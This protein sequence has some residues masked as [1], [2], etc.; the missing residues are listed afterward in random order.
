MDELQ[1]LATDAAQNRTTG[2]FVACG[3]GR[4]RT[5]E[6]IERSQTVRKEGR[7]RGNEPLQFA[8]DC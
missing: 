3:Q 8:M 4:R 6:Y 5:A 2:C 1:R 7:K